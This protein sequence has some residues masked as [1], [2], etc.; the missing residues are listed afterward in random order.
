V[1]TRRIEP[2]DWDSVIGDVDG[3][4]LVVA[5]PGTGK[6][7]F[8]VRRAVHLIERVGVEADRLLILTF[9]RR[10]AAELTGRIRG[11]L[12]RATGGARAATFHSFAQR[13]LEIHGTG[14][15]A[16]LLTGP[17]QVRFV[18]SLLASDDPGLWPVP[19][20]GLLASPTF[21]EEVADFLLRCRERLLGPAE[22]ADMADSRPDWRALPA[23]FR[24][25]ESALRAARRL[26]YGTLL[27]DATRALERAEVADRVGDQHRYVLV[28]EFQDTSPAQ[29][30]LL[31][32]A[33]ARHRAITVAGDPYQSIYS[34]RG[35]ELRNM[36]DFPHRFRDA[37]GR[38]ATRLVLT[39]SFR[40]PSP[41]LDA[42]L[43]V[44]ESGSLPGSAGPVVP[45]PHAG[46]VDAYVFDQQSAEAEWI[47]S[48]VERLIVEEGMAA[49]RLA[50]LVRSKRHLLPELS[51]ALE[52]RGIDHDTPDRRL[53]DHPVVR[54]VLDLA[55]LAAATAGATG[56]SP[57]VDRT[58][59]RVL[60]GPLCSLAVSRERELVRAR[61]RSGRSWS[62]ILRSHLS[63]GSEIADLLDDPAW[64]VAWPA[65][66][67]F[68]HVWRHLTA[69]AE[70]AMAPDRRGDRA[71]LAAFGQALGRQAD[72][73]PSISLLGYLR[74]VDDDDFE[75]T[76]LLAPP[77]DATKLV[78]TTL[79]QAKGLEFDIVFIAD[80]SEGV[81]PDA[82]RSRALLQP[83]LLSPGR[84]DDPA[85]LIR[86]RLQ[87]E[88]RLAYTAMTRA[89]LRV[90]WTATTAG[91]EESGRRPSRFLMAAVGGS[92]VD[93]LKP[94]P[95][96]AGPPVSALEVEAMLRRLLLDPAQPASRRLAAARVLSHPP[97]PAVWTAGEF[98]GVAEPGPDDG[99][100][101]APLRLTPS[102]AEAYETCPRRYVFERR[103]DVGDSFSPYVLF[104]SLI[105]AVLE[106]S[107]RSAMAREEPRSRLDEALDVLDDLLDSVDFGGPVLAAA[108]RR[109]AVE[110]LTRLYSE[111]PGSAPVGLE[112]ELSLE[113]DG[114]TWRGRADRVERDGGG[115]LRIVDYKTGTGQP[116]KDD[117]AGSL[118]LGFYL[119]AAST[120]DTLLN[121]GVPSGAEFWYPLSKNKGWRPA[122]DPARLDT[123]RARLSAVTA[124]ISAEDW[125][126]RVG[127]SCGRCGI[128]LLCDRWPEG[129]EA[130]VE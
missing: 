85:G 127:A 94:P 97:R 130:F 111:W 113:I 63:R 61:L 3:P 10:S 31:E 75:A 76:P 52:R 71:A 82:R 128:R 117:A 96:R 122:F 5:G 72:R 118:Q 7:E 59:R 43:G 25:Y 27:V 88:M 95:P 22:L 79:H 38:P 11:R 23:F 40:V 91:V 28:D 48:E 120:D 103:L 29:A 32:L 33:T 39:T 109:R 21:A 87:E 58:M 92:A 62:E 12:Q 6:T 66:D 24:R 99:V 125:Q 20:R 1:T 50:V 56:G 108:W 67:G 46:R 68:W 70:T 45:A 98:A 34:F 30:R 74:L 105:H 126:P 112:H 57:E 17:E 93:S 84:V 42:A 14:S 89:R 81:F 15:D 64:A 80:A 116:T 55:L 83:H 19:F 100:I 44:V 107:E 86:F 101:R 36:A 35:A 26:D 47:A 104:G 69:L 37:D 121:L 129:R 13:L 114:T 102:Q 53:V 119:M 115:R 90:I 78:L 110:L 8:L 2:A 77:A 65:T 60:L 51:R 18:G 106:E 41:I 123:V 4:Q 73:D 124:G 9:S 16:T 54:A 49:D